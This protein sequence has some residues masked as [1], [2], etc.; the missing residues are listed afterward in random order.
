MVGSRIDA[1]ARSLAALSRR[2]FLGGSS[3]A[4]GAL[5]GARLLPAPAPAAC[6]GLGQPCATTGECCFNTVCRQR[7]CRCPRGW[8]DCGTDRCHYLRL[9][10]RHCGACGTACGPDRF[11]SNG[12]CI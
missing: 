11:C 9:A 10:Q 5:L 1:A 4:L 2:R 8:D 7:A 3:G 6:R 12:I